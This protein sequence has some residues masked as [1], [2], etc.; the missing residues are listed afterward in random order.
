MKSLSAVTFVAASS[1]FCQ[2]LFCQSLFRQDD[3]D[4][5]ISAEERQ[6][7]FR[8]DRSSPL[9]ASRSALPDRTLRAEDCLSRASVA[10]ILPPLGPVSAYK[11]THKV[12]KKALKELATGVRM[13]E[14]GNPIGAEQHFRNAIAIDSQYMEAHNNLATSLMQQDRWDEALQELQVAVSL[15]PASSPAHSNLGIAYLRLKDFVKAEREG[16]LATTLDPMSW[17]PKHVVSMVLK[18]KSETQAVIH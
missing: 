12:P 13:T 1:L 7:Q 10:P 17:K 3:K 4:P 15:D 2:S 14:S 5:C 11:L 9:S 8:A 6:A 16:R 18:M